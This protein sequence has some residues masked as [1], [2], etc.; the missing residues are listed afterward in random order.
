MNTTNET[1]DLD[2]KINK[3]KDYEKILI[4]IIDVSDK[5]LYNEA[6]AEQSFLSLINAAVSH[7]LRNPLHSLIGQ[8][9]ILKELIS[10]METHLEKIHD[11]EIKN[12]LEKSF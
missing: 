10:D 6:K 3:R 11:K 9:D 8:T 4:Q 12:K 2:Y 5:M 7:E 1:L